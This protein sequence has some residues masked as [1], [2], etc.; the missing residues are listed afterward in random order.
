VDAV[1]RETG[2]ARS[3]VPGYLAEFIARKKP[4]DITAW[5]DE[6]TYQRVA[7][8]CRVTLGDQV[9]CDVIRLVVAHVK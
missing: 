2:L 1:V 6:A 7:A 8:A 3:T 9:P 5:V 4:K